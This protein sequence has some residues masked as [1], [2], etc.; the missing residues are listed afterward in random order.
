MTLEQILSGALKIPAAQLDDSLDPTNLESWT[1]LAHI[2]LIT[3]LEEQY[4]LSF[5]T[6][7]IM[8]A[9]SIGALRQLLTAK[10]AAL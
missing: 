5:T 4:V 3:A 6:R 1:S 9:K 10:G 8:S 7:E 2:N